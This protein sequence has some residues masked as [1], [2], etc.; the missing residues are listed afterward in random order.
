MKKQYIH[1]LISVLSLFLF[2]QVIQA[3][4]SYVDKIS[5]KDYTDIKNGFV[6]LDERY[7]APPY[8]ISHRDVRLYI[9]DIEIPKPVRHP[10]EK[11][12]FENKDILNLSGS[13]KQMLSKILEIAPL[14]YKSYLEKNDILI[15]SSKGGYETLNIYIA[16]YEPT[17]HIKRIRESQPEFAKRLDVLF[18]SFLYI[19]EFNIEKTEPINS[20]FVFIDGRYID[21]PYVVERKGTG[22]FINNHLIKFPVNST[23]W[24]IENNI[25]KHENLTD[26]NLPSTINEFSS[27]FDPDVVNY[28]SMKSSYLREHYPIKEAVVHIK[29]VYK[30]LPCVKQAQ[31]D[32]NDMDILHVVWTDDSVDNIKLVPLNGRPPIKMDKESI[33]ERLEKER[34]NYE[35]RLQKGDYYFLGFQNGGGISGNMENAIEILTK[36]VPILRS[37]KSPEI[38]FQEIKK[39]GFPIDESY[40]NIITNFSASPQLEA[41]LK[42]LSEK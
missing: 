12:A 6:I 21:A 20:G 1:I 3:N 35:E 22:L 39:A 24:N 42:D 36:I 40:M 4:S 7:I 30:N 13:D 17:D 23:Y 37:T 15:F 38:K 32:S 34:K 10:G 29:D 27:S 33:L 19:K 9:N 25:K 11:Y 28:L 2:D 14:V 18:E 26:S 8:I 31:L 16:L 5:E 41:R